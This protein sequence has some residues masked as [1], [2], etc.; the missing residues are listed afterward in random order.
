MRL[1]SNPATSN[2]ANATADG[3]FPL[4]AETMP[5]HVLTL[6]PF[7][8]SQENEVG[9]CFVNE[10]LDALTMLGVT[11]TVIAVAPIHHR[12]QHPN[13]VAPAKWVRYPQVPGTIG[14]S[15]A[16]RFLYARLF[17]EVAHLHAARPIDVIH[18]HAALPCGQAA[19]LL[20][21]RLHIPYVITVH[22]LDVFNTCFLAGAP[23]EW[24]MRATIAAYKRASMVICVSRKVQK[25]LQDGTRD[26]IRSTVVYNGTDTE[27]F[28][29][30]TSSHRSILPAPFSPEMLSS[31]IPS[32][33]MSGQPRQEI[34]IVGNLN[35]SKG[36]ELVL[37][38][39]HRT[40]AA[41]PYLQC[42]I[43]GEGADRTRLQALARDLGIGQR[44]S[45]LGRQ[46]R[47][48][49][50]DAMRRCS[51]FVLPSN[52]EGFGCVYLEAMASAKLVIACRGQGIEEIVEHQKNGWLI[53]PNSLDELEQALLTLLRSPEL[54]LQLGES[55]RK[56][57]VS[58]LTLAHQAQQLAAIYRE[59]SVAR[60]AA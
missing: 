32:P 28:S 50:A 37:R 46:S 25:I 22:G 29:P 12:R 30:A 54:S 23:A 44:V 57:V 31:E 45:F 35:A 58:E 47:A 24:R 59:M 26:R 38:A 60:L 6:T 21:Q 8:P 9:G 49:V 19:S 14:L 39:I 4:R 3:P 42:R 17:R 13:P 18:A 56:T 40:A 15:S 52:N 55:A 34:L 53:S 41:F 7:F 48:A 27:L 5:L 1:N 51:V 10:P 11:S 16:G 20:A 36:Q 33:D 43:V 2:F